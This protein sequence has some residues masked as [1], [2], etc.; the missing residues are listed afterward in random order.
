MTTPSLARVLGKPLYALAGRRAQKLISLASLNAILVVRLDEIGDLVLTTPFLRE[1]RRNAQK[2][3]ITLVVKPQNLNL[4][5]LCPYVDE[6]LTF[7]WNTRAIGEA[8]K[9]LW[10]R[11]YDLAILPR[12]GADYYYAAALTYLSGARCRLGYSERV[13]EQKQQLNRG[14]DRLMTHV[15]GDKA[16]KHEV[17][18][19]LD[20]I[21]FLGGEVKDGGLEVWLN[22]QDRSF[23]AAVLA[24]HGVGPGDPVVA[25]A[26]GAGA[27][28][29]Q[30]SIERFIGLGR[31]LEHDLGSLVVVGGPEGAPLGERLRAELGAHVVNLAGRTTLRQTA[32][33]LERCRLT[34]TN[35]S[36]PM[37]LAAAAGSAVVEISAH[38]LNGSPAHPQSPVRF[39]PWSAAHIVV[40][41]Q[42]A[43]YPCRGS[44]EAR[45]PHCILEVRTEQVLAAA[46]SLL[47]AEETTTSADGEFRHARH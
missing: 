1:L 29:R 3:W 15:L 28:R 19:N 5:E 41:P 7:T 43:V 46:R 24:E 18:H 14:S 31:L 30:W 32:A 10:P 26:P 36:G 21:R 39:H 17:E 44:C 9:A 33:V 47:A 12:W 22:Q 2:A 37:H 45:E 38:A 4:V 16:P 35:D 40:Q 34:V 25:F 42:Q 8:R 23:A 6:I 27:A 13:N 20:V 11:R